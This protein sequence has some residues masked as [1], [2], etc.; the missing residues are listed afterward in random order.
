MFSLQP[1]EKDRSLNASDFE[2]RTPL[3]YAAMFNHS[4]LVTFLVNEGSEI[5]PLDKNNCT[6]L[7]LAA[8]KRAYKTIK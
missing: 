3:H 5:N 1:E 7:H 8:S 6:P 4:E 2:G